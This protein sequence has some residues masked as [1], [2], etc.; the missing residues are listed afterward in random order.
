MPGTSYFS[1]SLSCA[2]FPVQ[3]GSFALSC[4]P[5]RGK[6]LVRVG[7]DRVEPECFVG[8][9]HRVS[10]HGDLGTGFREACVQGR[11]RGIKARGGFRGLDDAGLQGDDLSRG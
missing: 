4:S 6:L 3:S 11:V 2:A 10:E 7:G 5:A 9:C 1:S 8:F